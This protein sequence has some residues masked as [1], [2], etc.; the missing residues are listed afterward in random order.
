MYDFTIYP[1]EVALKS[2][3]FLLHDSTGS[4]VAALLLLSVVVR[5]ITTPI[6]KFANAIV[7]NEQALQKVFTPQL[8]RITRDFSGAEKHAAIQ[9]LYTRYSYHPIM[10]IR[11]TVGLLVQLP[12]FIAAFIMIGT[13]PELKGYVVPLIG[14]LG[15]PDGILAGINILP[16]LMTVINI[17]A[18]YTLPDQTPKSQRQAVIL[19]LAFLVLLY[20]EPAALVI[21]WTMN[22]TLSLVKS[23]WKKYATGTFQITGTKRLPAWCTS[24]HAAL[25]CAVLEITL[26][27]I[28]FSSMIK[29]SPKGSLDIVRVT[30]FLMFPILGNFIYL[31]VTSR[32]SLLA[33][34]CGIGATLCPLLYHTVG[35]T[36]AG[37][38]LVMSAMVITYYV[39]AF[40]RSPLTKDQKGTMLLACYI[41]ALCF[42]VIPLVLYA[43]EPTMFGKVDYRSVIVSLNLF[44]LA[45]IIL[46]KLSNL[47]RKAPGLL[48]AVALCSTGYAYFIKFNFGILRGVNFISDALLKDTS[49][50]LIVLEVFC[51][52]AVCVATTAWYHR[53][54]KH[55]VP[56][57]AISLLAL[58]ADTSTVSFEIAQTTESPE[59][60][61]Q[62]S[63]LSVP[64]ISFSRH[65]KNIVFIVPD[66]AKGEQ[67]RQLFADFPEFSTIFSGFTFYPNTA[68]S[69]PFTITN[70]A[71]LIGGE[72]YTLPALQRDTERNVRKKLIDAYSSRNTALEANGYKNVLF[73][74][75]YVDKQ[76]VA[77]DATSIKSIA[78]Y[79]PFIKKRF[80]FKTPAVNFETKKVVMLSSFRIAPLFVKSMLYNSKLWKKILTTSID[81]RYVRNAE[82]EAFIRALP[83][84]STTT[85]D[86]ARNFVQIWSMSTHSPFVY[87]RKR[88]YIDFSKPLSFSPRYESVLLFLKNMSEWIG[89]MK[90]QGVYANTKIIIVSDHG[91]GINES[92]NVGAANAFM[93]VKDFQAPDTPMATDTSLMSNADA[94]YFV[95]NDFATG[96]LP[97]PEHFMQEDRTLEYYTTQQWVKNQLQK[98][99]FTI[100]ERFA[101][102][103]DVTDT[104][105]WTTTTE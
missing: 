65:G 39:F 102:T 52:A 43:A 83:L 66:S 74:L 46:F 25:L 61:Q 12:F 16:I 75:D 1:I 84:L 11:G 34:L 56:V 101:L 15:Q 24:S 7:A 51:L 45:A 18:V 58:I 70:I 85:D 63:T 95:R 88:T 42:I 104:S 21:Y 8:E 72:N 31:L 81:N 73:S 97:E 20:A 10:A 62:V 37:F 96:S 33:I 32:Q 68:A 5:C 27:I 64:P 35:L 98:P 57:V 19:A 9:R 82:E 80:N 4:Y 17:I 2:L 13:L 55:L 105:N 50:I 14:D 28:S 48:L 38:L 3:F 86:A 99:L 30:A 93:M 44:A 54:K 78:E 26:V 90:A 100:H 22:N 67:M 103:G 47:H 59:A 40:R 23:L 76:S 29:M 60:L 6:E 87:D 89:W 36:Y 94:A 77:T 53:L 71:A 69:G 79:M 91:S 41:A 49:I 92:W